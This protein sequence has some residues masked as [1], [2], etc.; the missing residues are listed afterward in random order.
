M[1]A[2]LLL[3]LV[4]A[5]PLASAQLQPAVGVSLGAPGLSLRPGQAQDVQVT[6]TDQGPLDGT[7][8]LSA[9]LP[10]GWSGTA[11]PSSLAVRAGQS[12]TAILHVASPAQG[13]AGTG[14]VTVRAVLR[15][16]AGRTASGA[17]ALDVALVVDPPPVLPPADL[18]WAWAVALLALVALAAGLR[19]VRER[20]IEVRLAAEDKPARPGT[21]A[22]IGVEVRN[23]SR[24]AR[25]VDLAVRG[26]PVGWAAATSL[27]SM[28]LAPGEA[29]LCS[30]AVRLP[31]SAEGE[32]VVR[33]AARPRG[34]RI[35]RPMDE[36]RVRILP[37]PVTPAEAMQ[38]FYHPERTLAGAPGGE[39]VSPAGT[40]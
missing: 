19:V 23:R 25:W 22:Y 2:A 24:R 28:H 26:A 34:A 12:A 35:V 18:G 38:P 31:E 10:P 37:M 1:R 29:Q 32:G 16:S 33:V 17:A 39:A 13:D 3:A 9:S 36:V 5:A 40:R 6:V 20:G 30:L 14:S 27:R 21:Y 8:Q 15:D 4:L 7:A 11:E